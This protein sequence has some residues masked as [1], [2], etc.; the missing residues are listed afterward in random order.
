MSGSSAASDEYE[1]QDVAAAEAKA[2]ERAKHEARPATSPKANGERE[3]EGEG[4]AKGEETKGT[5]KDRR[6]GVAVFRL[7]LILRK[8][9]G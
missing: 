6:P 1:R 5:P 4:Q 2:K 3:G 8:R 7:V 9:I